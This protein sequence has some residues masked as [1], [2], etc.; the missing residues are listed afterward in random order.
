MYSISSRSFP[1][2]LNSIVTRHDGEAT[3]FA[4]AS[5]PFKGEPHRGQ[6]VGRGKTVLILR[7]DG[8][9]FKC[10]SA[11]CADCTFVKLLHLLHEQ[12]G[13]WPSMPI[14]ERDLEALDKRW[15]S[16]DDLSKGA[17]VPDNSP[18]TVDDFLPL[19]HASGG[20]PSP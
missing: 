20:C 6:N 15:G 7:P 2:S 17:N 11:D 9:G 3:Y 19:L 5:C 1:T 13:H 12:T 14:W 18:F 10:F 8:I 16:I 4:L